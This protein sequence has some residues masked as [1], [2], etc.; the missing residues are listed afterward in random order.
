MEHWERTDE[1]GIRSEGTLDERGA[2]HGVYKQWFAN[3]QLRMERPLKRGRYHGAHRQFN[4]EGDLLC[5]FEMV[6]GDGCFV[7]CYDSGVIRFAMDIFI[8]DGMACGI[9]EFYDIYGKR[10]IRT[11]NWAGRPVK[12]RVYLKKVAEL[13]KTRQTGISHRE[14]PYAIELMQ[15]SSPG[16]RI[17]NNRS[18][19]RR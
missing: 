9:D 5:Q 8:L 11:Y 14:K 18:R 2:P 16:T 13:K 4:Q 7:E 12:M 19:T 15:L 6:D 3:G 17:Q 10:F 1:S